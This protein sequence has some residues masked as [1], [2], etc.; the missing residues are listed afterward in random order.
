M[1]TF[2][3]QLAQSFYVSL[4]CGMKTIRILK[5]IYAHYKYM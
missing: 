4:V 3:T 1:Q 5:N 2:L